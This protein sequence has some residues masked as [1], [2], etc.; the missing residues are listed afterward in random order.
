M[1]PH[2]ISTFVLLAFCCGVVCILIGS[3]YSGF[4]V[5]NLATS[6]ACLCGVES[7]LLHTICAVYTVY[8]SYNLCCVHSLYFIQF[9]LCTQFI[10]HTICVVYTVYTSYNLCCVHSLYFIQ[11]V[12]CTQFILH[13]ICA[14]YTVY[15]WICVVFAIQC[16]TIESYLYGVY[17]T[18]L[19]DLWSHSSL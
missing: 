7:L 9:V 2:S 10:L 17:A 19:L 12:L 8:T 6:P 4:N 5:F 15:T 16:S 3:Q 18:L 11:F 1:T 13:T 14:V